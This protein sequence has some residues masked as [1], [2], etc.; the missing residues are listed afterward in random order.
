MISKYYYESGSEGP[1]L[2]VLGAVHGDEPCGTYG[3]RRIM[4]SLDQAKLTLKRGR[5]IFAPVANPKAFE[6]D[7]RYIDDNLNRIIF[8]T[9]NPQNNEEELAQALIPLIDDCDYLLDMHAYEDPSPDAPPFVFQ[10][11]PEPL[12]TTFTKALGI[13]DVFTGW[14]E[15][16][17]AVPNYQE[18]GTNAYAWA[19]GKIALTVECGEKKSSIAIDV[20][21]NVIHNALSQLQLIHE[22]LISNKEESRFVH[23][24]KVFFKEGEGKLKRD[25]QHLDAVETG[26]VLAE[27]NSGE[28]VIAD[29]SGYIVMPTPSADIGDE[30]LYLGQITSPKP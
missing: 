15:M 21:E 10:D 13:R 3:I 24:K 19:Q 30:W 27:Y 12:A 17:E 25:W 6:A 14:P 26:T 29:G 1:T 11:Y 28:Q 2:L 23:M 4:D 8:P 22:P 9:A 5:I 20:A 7:Q 18:N 16:Y